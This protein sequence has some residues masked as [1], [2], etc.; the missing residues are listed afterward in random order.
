M[1]RGRGVSGRRFQENGK[2]IGVS[3]APTRRNLG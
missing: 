3:A 2:G 1:G